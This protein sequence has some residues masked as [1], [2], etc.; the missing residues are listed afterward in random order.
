MLMESWIIRSWRAL[1]KARSAPGA[2]T[3]PAESLMAGHGGC[4]G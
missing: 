2:L 3:R 1:R 4:R